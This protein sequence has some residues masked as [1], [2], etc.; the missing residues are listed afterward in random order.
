[1]RLLHYSN[2]K[3]QKLNDDKYEYLCAGLQSKP[4]GLWVSVEGK[5]DWKEWCSKEDFQVD[6]LKFVHEITLKEDANILHLKTAKEIRDFGKKYPSK[7]KQHVRILKFYH[8]DWGSV[9][10]KY[11]GIIIAPYQWQCRLKKETS[12]YYG[13]D[14]ASGCIWDLSCIE[15]FKLN[16][17]E[18]QEDYD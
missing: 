4:T 9:K 3:I 1:M 16:E 6:R 15:E 13:W 17:Q 18:D 8:L 12:W 2:N 5:D 7:D 14:C 11:Q 10:Q